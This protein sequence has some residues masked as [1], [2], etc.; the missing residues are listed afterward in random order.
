[1][2]GIA[3]IVSHN[4]EPI[5]C[6]DVHRILQKLTHRGRDHAGLAFPEPYVGLG[7]RRL[8]IIDL[9]QQS[10]QP[11]TYASQQLYLTFNGEIYNYQ[12]IKKFLL[13][14]NYQFNTQSDSE[15][16]LAAYDYWG[17]RCVEFF[18]GMFAFAIW[19]QRKKI[20]FCARDPIGIKPFYYY[21]QH[22]IFAFASEAIALASFNQKKLNPTAITAYFMSMYVATEESIFAKIYKLP[23]GHTLILDELG[24]KHIQCFWSITDFNQDS[25]HSAQLDDL[26]ACLENAV[27]QQLQSDVPVGGFLS[28]GVD[29][30]LITALAAPRVKRYH[31]YSVGYEGMSNN[32]LPYARELAKRF[33]TVHHEVLISAHDAMPYLQKALTASSE[34]IADSA[35]VATFM[36]AELAAADGVK[37]LLNGTGGDEIFAGYTRY[38]GELSAKRK[39]LFSLPNF[40]KHCLSFLP[41]SLKLKNRL[42]HIG[43]DMLLATGGS[44]QLAAQ[45]Q[46][47]TF[48]TF[49]TTLLPELDRYIPQQIPALYQ[50]MLFDLTHYLPDQLLF[51]LDQM[52]MAHTVEGRVPLL[53]IDVIKRAYQFKAQEHIKQRQTKT[54]LKTIAT[55]LLGTAY[56]HRKKQGF[57]ASV[58]WW[59][60]QNIAEF[61]AAAE[62]HK[63]KDYFPHFSFNSI[64]KVESISD[65]EANHLF[66]IY[67][68]THWHEKLKGI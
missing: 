65:Q 26:K 61:L 37:V 5:H 32:E 6:E 20:L 11:M 29:S 42:H 15:I 51:L 27:L 58:K 60:Q 66:L 68:F 44:Y 14:K 28:G 17:E 43:F 38:N 64:K 8:S 47:Q 56:V 1:M 57:A 55:P 50:R 4:G 30:G 10:Q 3:G 39:I 19:D 46:P 45:L 52:T 33:D 18:N 41:L 67:C 63:L 31:T 2:C 40:L 36:L 24:N 12:A 13:K 48:K 7:H 35:M 34:P 25:A 21:H 59:V 23:P 16:I 62:Q 49:L 22:K 9:N 53:D 54:L